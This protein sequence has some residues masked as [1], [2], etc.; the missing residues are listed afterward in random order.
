MSRN[1][2]FAAILAVSALVA[3]TP[4]MA[5]DLTGE[6]FDYQYYY[7]SL[8]DA[9]S[10]ASNGSHVVGAGV[11]VANIVDSAGT[12]D[13]TSDQII[14]DFTGSSWFN[15][16]D[17]NGFVITGLPVSSVSVDAASTFLG[18]VVTYTGNTISVN[19]EGLSF[20]AGQQLVLDISSAVPEAGNLTMMFAGLCLVGGLARRRARSA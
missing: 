8:S 1:A 15:G 13:V 3:A 5:T 18:A 11:E 12:L 2:V 19:F 14:V 17:F 16:A 4:A 20:D 10:N 9:Y 6:T 7:P